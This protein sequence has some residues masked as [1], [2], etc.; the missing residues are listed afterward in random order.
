MKTSQDNLQTFIRAIG[1]L[2]RELPHRSVLTADD[3]MRVLARTSGSAAGEIL[4]ELGA[5]AIEPSTAPDATNPDGAPQLDSDG[6]LRVAAALGMM[7]SGDVPADVAFMAAWL[8]LPWPMSTAR[9][10]RLGIQLGAAL[11]AIERRFPLVSLGAPD[12]QPTWTD[13]QAG[14]PPEPA[15]RRIRVGH[16]D[17]GEVVWSARV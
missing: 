12:P 2:Q 14:E 11:A 1:N 3:L 4:Q 9:Q 15:G 6:W 7:T 10:A 13:W 8:A 17:S 16:T 5:N